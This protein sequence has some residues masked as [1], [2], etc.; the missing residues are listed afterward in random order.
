[1]FRGIRRCLSVFP[2]LLLAAQLSAEYA[3][4]APSG[5]AGSVIE[6]SPTDNLGQLLYDAAPNTTFLLNDGIYKVVSNIQIRAEGTTARSK[7]GNRA[8]VVLDGNNGGQPLARDDFTPEILQIRASDVTLADLT[9]RY[10]RDHGIHAMGGSEKNLTNIVLHNLHV[11]DCGQ[12]LIKVNSNGN[13][14]NSHWVDSSVLQCS[15]VEFIDNSVMQDMGT[16]FYTGG[17]DVHGGEGWIIRGNTFRNIQRNGKAMEHAVHMWNKCRGTLVE[18]NRFENCFRAIGFGMKLEPGR[19]ER[20]YPDSAGDSPYYDHIGG[21]IRNNVVYNQAGIHL[22]TGVE[23]MNVTG[24]EVYH[25][26]VGSHDT[27]FNSMEYRWPNTTVTMK[28]NLLT[29]R[30]M[31][32][33]R[34]QATLEGNVTN[35]DRSLFVD[36]SAGDLHLRSSALQAIDQ[37]VPL[38]DPGVDIDGQPRNSAPDIGADEV[39]ASPTRKH[40]E[41][42]RRTQ[43]TPLRLFDLKGRE[44]TRQHNDAI[45]NRNTPTQVIVTSDE[46]RPSV[47]SN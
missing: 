11:Y 25:N 38:P 17:L 1:M 24:V 47:K 34:A 37:G 8:A 36:F 27:P 29:H 18:N 19:L 7:S 26:T 13:A 9:I 14:A 20:H 5:T 40:P 6:V 33:D 31:R 16:Y 41:R 23:L 12:Q 30:L 4:P 39:Q 43:R 44:V 15:L 21:I 46:T 2:V 3:C 28:N 35:A 22:E 42:S 32:R 45:T 10:A